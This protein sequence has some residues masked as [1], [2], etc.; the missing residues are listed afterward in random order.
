MLGLVVFLHLTTRSDGA[1]GRQF[2]KLE[3]GLESKT[4]TEQGQKV[5][6]I[7]RCVRSAV[8]KLVVLLKCAQS[9]PE[10]CI[11]IRKSRILRRSP[12]YSRAFTKFLGGGGLSPPSPLLL[13]RLMVLTVTVGLHDFASKSTYWGYIELK[14]LWSV[15]KISD[16]R[17]AACE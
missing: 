8:E 6:K 12:G 1:Q 9:A 7:H 13:P 2:E 10:I 11:F 16:A 3:W 14:K 4:D 15:F 17:R 5:T